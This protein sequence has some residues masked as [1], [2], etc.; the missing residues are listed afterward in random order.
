M[1]EVLLGVYIKFQDPTLLQQIIYLL[2]LIIGNNRF[3]DQLVD[4]FEYNQEIQRTRTF[5]T[6]SIG[7]TSGRHSGLRRSLK[8]SNQSPQ[9]SRQYQSAE[10][11]ME[12]EKS[13]ASGL[14]FAW[15]VFSEIMKYGYLSFAGFLF[16]FSD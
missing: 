4:K 14:S 1:L 16:L 8:P 13:P 10:S 12:V 3:S 5:S 6:S 9:I 11:A 2:T 15:S 7:S